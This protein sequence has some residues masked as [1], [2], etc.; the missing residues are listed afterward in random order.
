[1][2][3]GASGLRV[4]CIL[5]ALFALTGC[6]QG[7]TVEDL[8]ERRLGR[9][10]LLYGT[11]VSQNAGKPPKSVDELQKYAEARTKPDQLASFG[12]T[13][14]A[15]LFVSPRDGTA[16]AMVVYSQI[17]PPGGD[18]IVVFYE[19]QAT[20]GNRRV[21]LLGGGSLLVDEATFRKLVPAARGAT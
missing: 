16:Y 4:G 14:V 10:G 2:R 1:M 8:T 21:A 15:D 11:F 5:L 13:K 20:D 9:L 7:P 19:S 18:P 6:S 3:G 12:A 17:P